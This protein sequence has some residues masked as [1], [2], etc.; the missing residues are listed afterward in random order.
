MIPVSISVTQDGRPATDLHVRMVEDRLLSP[1]L[2]QMAI[3]SALGDY[4]VEMLPR[5]AAKQGITKESV[6]RSNV[7][8]IYKITWDASSDCV[9]RLDAAMTQLRQQGWLHHLARHPDGDSITALAA[10][11]DAQ[12]DEIAAA[13]KSL[14][15]AHL[16]D[17][18]GAGVVATAVGRQAIDEIDGR[19]NEAIREYVLERPHSATVYGLVA[20]MQAG[21][22]TVE[23]AMR[24]GRELRMF[25]RE[26]NADTVA[27]N[28]DALF[29]LHASALRWLEDYT[30][31]P[32]PF[33]KFDF[34]LIPSFQFG[35]MEHAGAILY[36]AS[37]MMLDAL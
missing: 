7:D 26:T 23:H 21:R 5:G 31:I 29:D 9:R 33:G 11:F 14:A 16:V 6:I 32:Y 22:F 10:H 19:G 18:D 15:T 3:F 20:S 2:L 1:W 24:N 13:A 36:N 35:G 30:T 25:H 34:V 17:V 12:P 4:Q 27:R 8:P 37:S 28:R